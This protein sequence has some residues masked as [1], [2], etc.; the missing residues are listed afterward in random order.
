MTDGLEIFDEAPEEESG[1]V[2]PMERLAHPTQRAVAFLIDGVLT[3]AVAV[4]V[5]SIGIY[6]GLMESL[7]IV[8]TVPAVSALVATVLTAVF[9]T[10]PGKWIVGIR[11]VDATTGRVPGLRAI[12]RGLVIV[13]P[14]AVTWMLAWTLGQV[15]PGTG[16]D[17]A[18]IL[19]T[20]LPGLLW[21]G[22]LVVL[23]LRPRHRGVQDLAGRSVVVR[24]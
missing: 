10:T 17:A 16:L 22:L 14:F 13:A 6:T 1:A 4:L 9:G 20:L 11:V 21:A 19:L 8:L 2:D 7:A 15:A 23:I 5:V 12:P 18:G 3:V 24:R